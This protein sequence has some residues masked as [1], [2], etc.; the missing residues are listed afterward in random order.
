MTMSSETTLIVDPP[1]FEPD[2]RGFDLMFAAGCGNGSYTYNFHRSTHRLVPEIEKWGGRI[3]FAEVLYGADIA[4]VRERLFGI[5]LRSSHTHML[6]VDNDMGFNE[7]DVVRM[8][9]WSAQGKDFIG[10]AGPKKCTPFNSRRTRPM[11]TASSRWSNSRQKPG[12]AKL[13]RSAWRLS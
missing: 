6:M 7:R 13:T 3:T 12:S 9:L 10:A 2:L 4:L 1:L 5:F 8:A 11:K